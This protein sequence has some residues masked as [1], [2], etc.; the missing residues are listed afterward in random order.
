L[1]RSIITP[2][3]KRWIG[4]KTQR[5]KGFAGFYP[6]KHQHQFGATSIIGL[7]RSPVSFYIFSILGASA[8]VVGSFVPGVGYRGKQGEAYSPLNH[9]ISELGEVEVSRIAWAFDLGLI[10]SGISL[11]GASISLGLMLPGLLSKL[12]MMAG[13]IRSIALVLIGRHFPDEQNS[14]LRACGNDLFPIW[15]TDDAVYQP[16]DWAAAGKCP[17]DTKD[18]QPGWAAGDF[19][20]CQFSVFD[21]KIYQRKG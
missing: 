5:N 9:F 4:R 6:T 10:L 14:T 16:C 2:N 17:G 20:L 21:P 18:L 12:G 13:V 19:V 1:T 11:I 7:F 15:L 8:A 3:R